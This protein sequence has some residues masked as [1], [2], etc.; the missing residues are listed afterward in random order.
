MINKSK[1]WTI[2]QHEYL[3]K[4]KSKGFIIGT[5]LAP[6]GIV[7]LIAFSASMMIM[8]KDT[9]ERKLAIIDDTNVIGTML[10]EA[11]TTKYYLSDE[12]SNTL[13]DKII[14]QEIDGFVHIPNDIIEKGEV[15]VFSEG[16][17]GIGFVSSLENNLSKIVRRERMKVMNAD[18]EMIK[19]VESGV[20]VTTQKVTEEGTQHDNTQGMAYIG[21]IL[22]FIIYFLVFLY[23]GLVSRAVVEE[24][25][26]RIIEVIASSAKPFEIMLG[27]VV[28]IGM[29]GL[30]QIAVW[31]ILT[32]ILVL[33]LGS[34]IGAFIEIDPSTISNG[35]S[36]QMAVQQAQEAK[37]AE[38][39]SNVPQI[40]I[41]L[42]I[43]FIFF[44]ITGYFIY[45]SLFAAVGS[46]VD[47]EQDAGQ[48]QMPLTIPIMIP[49]FMI[50]PIMENPDST[51]AS[52]A[53]L[54]PFFTPILMI[55]RLASTQVP[56]WE[57]ILAVLLQ[58]L[59]FIAALWVAGRI[60]RIG[61]LMTGKKPKLTDLIKWI[62]M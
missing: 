37:V 58:I 10:A 41:G 27:K 26:N 51:I 22:G 6:I 28:G 61:I 19:L 57:I 56:A 7:A 3:L 30:S 46:A 32:S 5:F 8:F 9:T 62:K 21:Y 1:I 43:G 16:G 17:G 23:G 53:S 33:S 40:D 39:M 13:K 25:A 29:V 48:L 18:E 31:I 20:E 45:A 36:G 11:D 59:T 24:K 14:K 47:N 42:I 12:T 50:Q 35:M 4:V 52:I 34:I 60:Y 15:E 44:F 54:F 49:I 38:I 55:V 2:I